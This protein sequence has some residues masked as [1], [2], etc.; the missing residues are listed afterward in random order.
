MEYRN[1]NEEKWYLPQQDRNSM[2]ANWLSESSHSSSN[3][4]SGYVEA[5][6]D[7]NDQNLLDHNHNNG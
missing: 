6:D 5:E 2:I 7:Q 4:V 3:S 1:K